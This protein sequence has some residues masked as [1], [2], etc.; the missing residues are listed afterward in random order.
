MAR[1]FLALL[2]FCWI[3]HVSAETPRP[4]QRSELQVG[5]AM[6]IVAVRKDDP[7][8]ASDQESTLGQEHGPTMLNKLLNDDQ[9]RPE[10]SEIDRAQDAGMAYALTGSVLLDVG[11]NFVEAEDLVGRSDVVVAEDEDYQSH[12]VFLRARWQFD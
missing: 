1:A 3:N 5:G 7:S 12:H 2:F 8:D 9:M 10:S 6:R 4:E 11:Y